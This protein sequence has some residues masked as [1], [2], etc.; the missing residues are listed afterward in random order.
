MVAHIDPTNQDGS[1]MYA[2]GRRTKTI[3]PI[4]S[5]L[6]HLS[7]PADKN[8]ATFI[9]T[10][11]AIEP[12]VQVARPKSASTVPVKDLGDLLSSVE[13]DEGSAQCTMPGCKEVVKQIIGAQSRLST[14]RQLLQDDLTD[15]QFELAEEEVM[16]SMLEKQQEGSSRENSEL[17]SQNEILQ[18][19]LA[20]LK[21]REYAMSSVKTELSNK[22]MVMEAEKAKLVRKQKEVA[23]TLSDLLW[24]GRDGSEKED[25]SQY[26]LEPSNMDIKSVSKKAMD[27][28][29][30]SVVTSYCG[31]ARDNVLDYTDRVDTIKSRMAQFALSKKGRKKEDFFENGL[32]GLDNQSQ[33]TMGTRG[34]RITRGTR[35]GDSAG[36]FTQN[37]P[38]S[39]MRTVNKT[40]QTAAEAK[41]ITSTTSAVTLLSPIN[42]HPAH[43][44]PL[45]PSR[46][47]V[48]N[49]LDGSPSL[50]PLYVKPSPI[51]PFVYMRKRTGKPMEST[52]PH[53]LP[54]SP[55]QQRLNGTFFDIDNNSV[56]TDNSYGSSVSKNRNTIKYFNQ[57][58]E[59]RPAWRKLDPVFYDEKSRKKFGR[60]S[61]VGQILTKTLSKADREKGKLFT[62]VLTNAQ[63]G[64]FGHEE[65]LTGHEETDAIIEESDNW[66]RSSTF[67]ALGD[68]N[69]ISLSM[70][71]M[72]DLEFYQPPK[73]PLSVASG[74]SRHGG[75]R[76]GG[77]RGGRS[78]GDSRG[79]G[80]R[81]SRRSKS[82]K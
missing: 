72:A 42:P 78:R 80:S 4:F 69:K 68:I 33:V 65:S 26:T 2:F 53:M 7:S 61:K 76:G 74:Q 16:V 64:V 66:H 24:K 51:K 20:E 17:E 70:E 18:A 39:D 71:N 75:S 36:G 29:E 82:P 46:S 73:S 59:P 44:R 23:K 47:L 1:P 21:E 32:G 38:E 6:A 9:S 28:D 41:R 54:S 13:D 15:L 11:E 3:A 10:G 58:N 5:E 40:V 25:N 12:R 31:L 50:V 45:T 34:T 27:D 77:S 48:C 37:K 55:T 49:A 67:E 60:R 35:T 57:D 56:L 43:Q 8:F 22:V 81:G 19:T 62:E 79:G 52:L 30:G 14:E 63:P